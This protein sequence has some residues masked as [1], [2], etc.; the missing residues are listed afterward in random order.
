MC[1]NGVV[2]ADLSY[3]PGAYEVRNG[4]SPVYD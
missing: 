3:K 1:L 4:Q 2:F